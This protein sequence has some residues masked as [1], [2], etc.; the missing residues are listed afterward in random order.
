MASQ[1]NNTSRCVSGRKRPRGYAPWAPRA[2]TQAILEQVDGVLD[3]YAEH[4]PLTVRQIFYALVATADYPK[5]EVAYTRLCEIVNRAR[6]AEL[7][8]FNEIRD[9]GAIGIDYTWFQDPADFWDDVGHRLQ[10]YQRDRLQAQ[11][12]GIELWCETAGMLPQLARVCR[13]YSVRV[14]ASGGFASLSAVRQVVDRVVARAVSTV[15]LHVGDFDPSGEAVFEHLA[16]DVAA[17]VAEDRTIASTT[18]FPRRIALNGHQVAAYGLVTAPAKPTDSRSAKWKGE[19][20]Q[21]EALAPD[22]LA[23][24]VRDAIEVHLD[25]DKYRAQVAQE[26][27]DLVDLRRALPRGSE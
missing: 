14:Y 25:L 23:G 20:C 16:E 3:K 26:D 5:T 7:I 2:A 13:D 12:V 19:T 27:P 21:L 11:P 4:L 9:D 15:L 10:R 18:V 17:F 1:P 6:R 8:P 22:V 24:I